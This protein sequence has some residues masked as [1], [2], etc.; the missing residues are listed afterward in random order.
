MSTLEVGGGTVGIL[1]HRGFE[2]VFP[3][4][5]ITDKSGGVMNGKNI[6]RHGTNHG[7]GNAA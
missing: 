2:E 1:P 4:E 5:V 6:P 3:E 7:D